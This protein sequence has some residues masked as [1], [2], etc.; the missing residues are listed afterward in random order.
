[1]R[2]QEHRRILVVDDMPAIHDDFRKILAAR[3]PSPLRDLEASLFGD[4]APP[5][6]PSLDI[7]SAFQGREALDMVVAARESGRPYALAFVDMRM[8]P[9]WNGVETIERLWKADPRLEVVICTAYS[10]LSWDEV[11]ERLGG[12]E[13]VRIL[14]KPVE[15]AEIEAL[16]TQGPVRPPS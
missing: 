1:M 13:K 9:G 6:L 2:E 11:R 8:P 14:R 5:A 16:A 7:D 10:D 12:E 15:P 4:V 3:E